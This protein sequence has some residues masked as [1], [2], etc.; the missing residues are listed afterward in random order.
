MAKVKTLLEALHIS[1]DNGLSTDGELKYA[2]KLIHEVEDMNDAMR[3]CICA[4]FEKGPL[5]D[6]DVPSKTGRDALVEM[7]Y[8]AHIVVKG[9][10][11]YNACTYKGASAYR[12]IRALRLAEDAKV[13]HGSSQLA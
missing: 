8:M 9:Q 10:D 12:V 11:G 1:L 5:F 2:V 6:G 3:D 7:G 4:S 13:S